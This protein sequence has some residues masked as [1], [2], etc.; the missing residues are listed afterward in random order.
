MWRGGDLNFY[1]E[2]SP[3]DGYA[4]NFKILLSIGMRDLTYL[5]MYVYDEIIKKVS[6]CIINT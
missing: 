2:M 4:Y 3:S 5:H 6:Y 1:G